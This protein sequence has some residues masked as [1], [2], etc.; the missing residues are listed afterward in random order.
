MDH[1]F[2]F[3]LF[4]SIQ[5]LHVRVRR[6]FQHDDRSDVQIED[7]DKEKEKEPRVFCCE[8]KSRDVFTAQTFTLTFSGSCWTALVLLLATGNV[9]L[10]FYSCKHNNFQLCLPEWMCQNET[11]DRPGSVPLKVQS[12]NQRR[13]S[14]G[15][16]KQPVL[17]AAPE[18]GRRED[19][20]IH[21][22]AVF[23]TVNHWYIILWYIICLKWLL[24]NL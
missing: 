14:R 15:G 6:R 11:S 9:C 12:A 3:L 1:S 17:S 10:L 16:Q 19:V 8:N 22:A 20:E 5:D 18:R 23:T 4:V 24:V 7:G 2:P 21:I 13:G